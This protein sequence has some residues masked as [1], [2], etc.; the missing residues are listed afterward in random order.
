MKTWQIFSDDADPDNKNEI[1]QIETTTSDASF[2]PDATV[3]T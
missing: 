1:D 2:D 3:T